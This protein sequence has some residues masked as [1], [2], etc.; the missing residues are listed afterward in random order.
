MKREPEGPL[1]ESAWIEI[2]SQMERMYGELANSQAELEKKSRELQEAKE[3]ADNIIESMVDALIV[4]D[5]MGN[6]KMINRATLDLFGYQENEIIGRPIH[7][8]LDVESSKENLF[9]AGTQQG[10]PF[11]GNVVRDLEVDCRKQTGERIPVTF[12]GSAIKDSDGEIVGAVAVAKD[13]RQIKNLLV[14]A[15]EA[16]AEHAKATELG[17]AYAELQQLQTQLIQAEK[18][19]SIGKLAAGVAHEINNPLAGILL[20]STAALEELVP[21]DGIREIIEKIVKQT[22]R[23]KDIVKGLL[24]FARQAEPKTRLCDINKLVEETLS[25]VQNQSL[26]HNIQV[27]K[28]LCRSLPYIAIDG[29]Q[30]QQVFVNIILNA[31]EAMEG[32]GDL[33]IETSIT[34]DNQFVAIQFSDTGCG[35]PTAILDKIFEPF[36]TTKSDGHGTG[37]GLAICYGI[38]QRHGGMIEAKSETGRGATFIVKLPLMGDVRA[39]GY[40]A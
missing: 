30:I 28:I 37:L 35:I 12:S 20:Y 38:V 4:V 17:R 7:M 2:I 26:F 39:D 23:C 34:E 3:F 24:N 29:A 14:K 8:L 13:L 11:E 31:A 5:A 9:F 32:H 19:A 1:Q 33:N 25:F 6:I 10:R 18:M 16:E 36:F 27:N 21:D 40:E 15:A 22:T